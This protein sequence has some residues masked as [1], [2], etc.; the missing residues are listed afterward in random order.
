VVRLKTTLL[1]FLFVLTLFLNS[2]FAEEVLRL[3]TTTSIYETGLLDYLLPPFE[4]KH[5]VKVH[6]ISVGTGK[7]IKLGENGDVDVILVHAKKAEDKFV[8]D[9]FGLNRQEVMYNDFIIIGPKDDPAKIA[10][11]KDTPEALQRIYDCRQTFASRGDNSGTHQKEKYLWSKIGLKPAGAWYLE[12][13]Q[14]MSATLLLAD[15]K[16]AYILLDHATYLSH[17]DNLRLKKLVEGDKDLFNPYGVIAVSSSKHPQLALALI[18]WLTSPECQKMINNY[19]KKGEQLF[20]TSA[21]K[22]IK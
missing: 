1:F 7:A 14:G 10:G 17:K 2:I 8:A 3:A 22:T 18:T 13:G 4:I 12:T 19:K 6:I 20:Q 9:G 16:N 11:L 5:D 15:E 21:A